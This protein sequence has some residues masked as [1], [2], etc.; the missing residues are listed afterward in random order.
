MVTEYCSNCNSEIT[1]QWD[2]RTMGYKAFCPVCGF[3]LMLCDECQHRCDGEFTGDCDY[4]SDTDSCMFN[5][6]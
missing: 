3:R 5:A 6:V 4:S 1:M 2:T